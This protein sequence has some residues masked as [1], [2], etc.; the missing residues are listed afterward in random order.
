MEHDL[1]ATVTS[2]RFA[3]EMETQGGRGTGEKPSQKG[4]LKLV[5]DGA[6]LVSQP[7][8]GAI[9]EHNL[10]ASWAR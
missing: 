10:L 3:I 8:A 5:W 7:T 1:L 2:C 4:K 6:T 9:I